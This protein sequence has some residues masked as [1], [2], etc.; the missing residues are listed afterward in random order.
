[1]ELKLNY[2]TDDDGEKG[3]LIVP[4]GIE[5]KLIERHITVFLLLIVPYGIETAQ[6][7]VLIITQTAF[8]RTL[9]N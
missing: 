9:W 7:Q 2:L 8:N 5:T 4:Y 1:M 3:L 6:K